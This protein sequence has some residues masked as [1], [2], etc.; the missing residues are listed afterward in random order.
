MDEQRAWI[1]SRRKK[2]LRITAVILCFC[3][4]VK[5]YPDILETVSVFAGGLRGEDEV[6]FVSGFAELSEEIS[7]QTVPVGTPVEELTLPDT[8]EAYVTVK[9]DDGAEDEE[10]SDE[11]PDKSD[12][13]KDNKE[14][15][16]EGDGENGDDEENPGDGNKDGDIEGTEDENSDTEESGDENSDIEEA[17]DENGD[18][19]EAGD[20]NGDTGETETEEGKPSDE[21]TQQEDNATSEETDI[22]EERETIQETHTA[23]MPEYYAENM[24]PVQTLENTQTGEQEETVT[25]SGITWQSE[26]EYDGNTEETYIF[27]MVLPEG[28]ILAE[29]VSLPQITVTVEDDDTAILIQA[30]L[31]RIEALPELEEYLAA[32]PDMKEDAKGYTQWEERLYEYAEEALAIW[33]EYETLTEEQQAQ[34]PEEELTK[35]TE[36]VE[37]AEQLSE[38]SKVMAA[39]VTATPGIISSNQEWGAQTLTAGTYTINPGVTVTVSGCLTVSG[40]VTIKGGGK[41]VRASS[42]TG[43]SSTGSGAGIFYVGGGTLTLENMTVDGGNVNAYGPAIYINSGTV[44]MKTGAVIQNNI[45]MDTG[46]TGVHA[47]GGIYCGGTLN[48]DG[49]TI[50]DCRTSKEVGSN[51]YAHAGGGIYLKGTCNMTAGSITGNGASNGGGIYLASTGA[52]LRLY[53]GTISGNSATAAGNGIYYSTLNS[54][55]SKVYISGDAN[56]KDIIYLDNTSG[57]LYPY[58]TSTLH[59]QVTLSCNSKEEGK[60]L[61]GGSGYTLTNVDASKI[62]M[63]GSSLYSRLNNTANQIYLSQTEEPEAMWQESAGGIWKTGRFTTALEN[64]YDGGTIKLLTAIVIAEQTKIT[65]TVTITSNNAAEP[66]VMTRMPITEYGNITIVGGNLTLT[67]VIYDGNRDYIQG[68]E[69]AK[70]QSL[71]KV[72]N[73]AS[74]TGARLTLGAGAVVRDGYKTGGSGLFAV[75]GTME[76]NSG[77]VIENCEVTNDG[78]GTGGAVWVSANGNFTMNGGTI[79]RCKADGGGGAIS[80][81]GTCTLNG[82]SITGNTDTSDKDCAVYLRNSGGNLTLNGI[83]ISGNTY[84]VYN[85]DR[86]VSVAGDSTLSGSIYTTNAITASGNAVS[87]L[88]KTYTIMWPD[89]PATGTIVVKGSKDVSHYQLANTGYGL[90]PAADGSSNLVVAQSCKVSFDK[91]GGTGEVADIDVLYGGVYGQLPTPTRTGYTFDGWYTAVTGGS[92]V[93]ATTTVTKT[94]AHTLYAHWTV[95]TY[96]VTYNKN[97]GTITNESS[98]TSYTYGTGLTLPA[99]TRTGYTFGGWYENSDCSGTKVTKISTTATGAK[100]YYAKWTADTYTV[101]YNK[102][103]GTITNESNYTSYTYGTGLTLPTPTR[104]GYTFG[105]WYENSDC[106]GTKVTKISTTATGVKTYYAKWTANKYTVTFDY[107][108]AT[109][110]NTTADKEVVYDSVYGELPAPEKSNYTFKGWYT[111]KPENGEPKGDL[112]TAET[113]V[114][115]AKNHMLY[116][117]WKDEI[118][119]DKPVLQEG[120]TLPK[121]WK[122]EQTIPL[123]LRDNVAVT[124]LW[125]KIDGGAYQKVAGFTNTNGGAVVNYEFT[126]TVT[127]DHTYYFMAKDAA[128]NTSEDSEGFRVLLDNANPVIGELTYEN[129][130]KDFLDWII[131]KKSLIIKVPV[132]DEGSGVEQIS[133]CLTPVDGVTGGGQSGTADVKKGEAAITFAE[134]FK[135][136][137]TITCTDAVGNTADSVTIGMSGGGVI[138]EDTAPQITVLADR[139]E[140]D[141]EAT[142]TNGTALSSGYYVSAPALLVTVKDHMENAVT[143][144]I[145]SITYR[146]GDD[147]KKSVSVATNALQ[148]QVAFTIPA[149]EIPSGATTIQITAM[150]NAGNETS[151]FI[152][153]K[154]RGVEKTPAATIDYP[155]EMLKNLEP[156]AKYQINETI[157]PADKEGCIPIDESWFDTTVSI[158]KKGIG[159][160][161]SD[162]S[163]QSLAIPARPQTPM[164]TGVDVSM[165]G[166]TGKLSG[167]TAGTVYEIST[168]GGKTWET[169]TETANGSGEITGLAPGSYTVRVKA[170]V[171]NFVSEKSE[172]AKI[173]AYQIKVTFMANGEKY[174]E[175]SVDYGTALKEI[176]TVPDKKDAGDQIFAGEWCKDEQGSSPAVFTNI[177]ANMTVY[178][179][180]STGYTVTLQ[181]GTGYTLS[182][183][184]GSASPAKEGGS[185]TFK[186]ALN[187]GYEKTGSFALKVN[188]VKV[189]LTEAET[190][191][192]T[193]IRE[194]KTVTVTGVAKSV[195]SGGAGGTGKGPD[196]TT[197]TEDNSSADDDS[198]TGGDNPPAGGNP[199]AGKDTPPTDGRSTIDGKDDKPADETDDDTLTSGKKP[200]DT[201][202][203]DDKR[204]D[205][206]ESGDSSKSTDG[207]DDG[208]PADG[209]DDRALADNT[210]IVLVSIEDGKIVISDRNKGG[211]PEGSAGEYADASTGDPLATGTVNGM[212]VA[213]TI[214]QIGDGSD[215]GAVIVTVVCEEQAYTAGVADTVAVANAILTSEQIQFVKEGET[216]EI[217]IDVKDISGSVP[218]RDQEIIEGG[219]EA[220]QKELPELTLGMYIDISMFIRVGAGDWNAV[221]EAKEPIEV[222]IGIPEELQSEGREYYII[223]AHDGEYTFMSDMDDV[224]DTITISTELFSSYAIAYQQTN[225]ADTEKCGLCHICPTFLGIC[226]FIWLA[227]I[228]AV[229]IV[230]VI[231]MLRR[232]KKTEEV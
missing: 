27:T 32:E 201:T 186:F 92:K 159:S 104:T 157:Y 74:D 49:G 134:D 6:V 63:T 8:L 182:A 37:F 52:E 169:K 168:D 98:Y 56:V 48:I 40:A 90:R 28:Y 123:T 38:N 26:P 163:A 43:S 10:N 229:I 79:S 142:Q 179:V 29:G 218:I 99:P 228:G 193:D 110:G 175:I 72:G 151:K 122:K 211:T 214:L 231:V 205:G 226:Y 109:D 62:S 3:L 127:G 18:T 65:K 143:A 176:P 194:N 149:S 2:R 70:T 213:S 137:I 155:A 138:V 91:N 25:I 71:V 164:P 7:E 183:L 173:G 199:P 115:T 197:S 42:Y 112:V 9:V 140:P 68:T 208:T 202:P 97:S 57:E 139:S 41:L 198:L 172:P 60:I 190:Y 131:G 113:K 1:K 204:P 191:T 114:A 58:I 148:E 73:N 108:D 215:A 45:N 19:E 95:N 17:G 22:Q 94:T 4:L 141:T 107:Q 232:K 170:G 184:S 133:F 111:Q 196:N 154:V 158:V 11:D 124:E 88:T 46:G 119:P 225:E 153:V 129:E 50:K 209:T 14:K 80:V 203:E 156:G 125:V 67:N 106:S 210:V 20:E 85:G 135:G 181:G 34:I 200:G 31:E 103:K 69:S 120:K 5:T 105:G 195:S 147:T 167:L 171:S 102:N 87:S 66:C 51:A 212:T 146:V 126:E 118:T 116:A 166:G 217:R 221:T 192:M 207:T 178:A 55:T 96:T 44:N 177:T 78:K 145:E 39:A 35:L 15:P 188:N 128:G 219:I 152:T 136:T 77:A 23:T 162:S 224:P 220:Y 16:D 59:Y 81:D 187:T 174:R 53:G 144:G 222:V 130:T 206:T 180:Y 223:R 121:E 30:L 83:S 76:M 82:G 75:Y 47:A 161:T 132:T 24:I 189:E 12:Q 61:A 216:I 230:A 33:E 93:T 117:Y 100:T 13:N 54:A 165:S 89:S 86:S 36:W 21:D 160:D 227:V 150:D 185:F 84:S 101:T 64:V